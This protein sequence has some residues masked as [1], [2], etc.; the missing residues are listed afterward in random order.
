MNKIFFIVLLF[1]T[2]PQLT[3]AQK[4][5]PAPP[6]QRKY[7]PGIYPEGSTRYL[8]ESDVVGL[9]A[10]DLKIMRNEIYARHGYIFK[11]K[12][13]IDYFY[14]QPW[15]T[16]RYNSVEQRFSAIEKKNILFIRQYE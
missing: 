11:T 4:H 6:S 14:N 1:F 3:N 13:M 12:D 2:A 8:R 15:Y 7:V 5:A 10:W 9:T 16:P